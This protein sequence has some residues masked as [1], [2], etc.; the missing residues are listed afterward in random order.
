M[1]TRLTLSALLAAVA[2]LAAGCGFKHEPTGVLPAYPQTVRDA[3]GHEVSIDAAPKRIVSL[4]PGMTAALFSLGADKLVVGRSGAESYP[5]KALKLP[6]MVQNGKPDVKAISKAR[7]DV[8]LVP[9][10]MA[11]TLAEVDALQRKVAAIVYVVGGN[12]VAQVENDITELGLI[13]NQPSA[14]R[15]LANA[16]QTGV[17]AVQRAVA[18]QAPTP[19][20]VDLGFSYTID[21]G[22]ITADLLRLAGG[23]NVAAGS[24]TSQQLT[25]AQ[26]AQLAP[27]VYISQS[28]TGA[29]LG[30]LKQHK[31]TSHLPAVTQRRVVQIP[32]SMLTEDGP[33]IPSALA[34]IAR[35]LHPDAS[36]PK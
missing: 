29:T 16:V 27:D 23:Q 17:A 15:T 14:G 8:V 24:D 26:L 30:D 32:G 35:A 34:E 4:D 36:I 10:S 20:F 13:I 9:A 19:V 7:P 31:A 28:G 25:G 6:V 21:P 5:K 1:P 33:R 2:L 3:I 18:G 12:S 22:G 11:P